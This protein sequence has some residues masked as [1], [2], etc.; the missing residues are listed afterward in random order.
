LRTPRKFAF[1]GD[2]F[3]DTSHVE[4]IFFH[5]T[6]KKRIFNSKKDVMTRLILGGKYAEGV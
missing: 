6:L 4:K 1:L 5:F 3:G 2:F